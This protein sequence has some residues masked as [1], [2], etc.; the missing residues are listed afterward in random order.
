M[1][2]TDIDTAI[3]LFELNALNILSKNFTFVCKHSGLKVFL[4][5][6]CITDKFAGFLTVCV[7]YPKNLIPKFMKILVYKIFNPCSSQVR[8]DFFTQV[9]RGVIKIIKIVVLRASTS[10]VN[11]NQPVVRSVGLHSVT[12]WF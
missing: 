2:S 10:P 12:I 6:I 9:C 11:K 5:V 1:S 7:G 4:T 8:T 3:F